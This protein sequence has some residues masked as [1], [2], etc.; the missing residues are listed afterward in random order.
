MVPGNNKTDITVIGLGNMGSALSES[1]LSHGYNVTVWNRSPDKSLPLSSKG[2]QVA[3]DIESG[4]RASPASIICLLDHF[5]T[6]AVLQEKSVSEACSNRTLIQL[7]TMTSAESRLLAD[8]AESAG[9]RYLDGQILSYPDDIRSGCASIV[10]SG[11]KLDFA[12]YRELL[13]K[14][15]GKV[16]HVGEDIGAAPAFDKAHLAWAIGNYQVFLQ[17]AAMCHL[18]GVDLRAWC[19]YSLQHLESGAATRE[20]SIL[21]DQ[22]CNRNYDR[23]LDATMD[24]WKSAIDKVIEEFNTIGIKKSHLGNLSELT[25]SAIESGMAGK[26]IGVLFEQI[27]SGIEK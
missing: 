22:V 15:A 13:E 6:M 7:T 23:G 25:N 16:L 1:L 3:Q 12:N 10:C 21:A 8:W 17:V 11:E 14:M 27:L 9:A 5:A 4:L 19:D 2:A 26:E 24:V 18:A 20:L